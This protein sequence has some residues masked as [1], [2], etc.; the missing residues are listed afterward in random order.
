M[1]LFNASV[2]IPPPLP[3]TV[4]LPPS[5]TPLPPGPDV[6]PEVEEPVVPGEHTPV[7]EPPAIQPEPVR[8]VLH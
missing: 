3:N 7:H 2:D 1:P 4:P 5:P 8:R 6:P